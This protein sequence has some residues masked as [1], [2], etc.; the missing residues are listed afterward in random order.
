MFWVVALNLF[1]SAPVR[2]QSDWVTRLDTNGNGYIEP[3]ELNE[4]SRGFLGRFA[5]DFGIDLSRPNSVRRIEEA[6]RLYLERRSRDSSAQNPSMLPSS[7]VKGFGVNSEQAVIPDFGSGAIRHPY[8]KADQDSAAE[9]LQRYDRNRDGFLSFDEIESNRW[10]GPTPQ[11]FDFDGD[12][13]L[14]LVELAQRYAK[15]RALDKQE[16]IAKQLSAVQATASANQPQSV[17]RRTDNYEGGPR[18]VSRPDRGNRAL[19]ASIVERFDLNKNGLLEPRE[20]ASVGIEIVNADFNRDGRVDRNELGD[21]LFQEME[22][23]GN[24]L[25]E[26]LPTWFFEQDLNADGQIEMAEFTS[27]WTVEKADEFAAYDTNGDGIIT[28]DEILSSKL[29]AGGNFSNQTA[30]IL[31]PRSIVISEI[32]VDEDIVIGDLNLQL[33][34]THSYVEQLD[35]YLISPAGEKI[36]LFAGIGGSDDHFERTIFDDEASISITRARAPFKGNFQPGGVIKRQ[37]GLI[38]FKGKSL[39]GLWQLMIRSSR[40]DRTGVLH[41]WALLVK[42][43]QQSVDRLLERE[44]PIPTAVD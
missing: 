31:L 13:R 24:D 15:R 3:S 37:P 26:Q 42:P 16:E 8:T 34:I 2:A 11:S 22:R 25:S 17:G 9:A 4:R 18:G 41:D 40:S 44:P 12:G 36:E 33:S 6:A 30:S 29:V 23:Q 10:R 21:F 14:N 35:G 38:V 20:M 39:K 19:A 28:A 1:L 5:S 7:T 27:V 43:D 32:Q